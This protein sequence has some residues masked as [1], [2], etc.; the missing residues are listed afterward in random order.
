MDTVRLSTRKPSE[1]GFGNSYGRRVYHAA[2][3]LQPTAPLVAAPLFAA[4]LDAFPRMK[5]DCAL[6][7]CPPVTTAISLTRQH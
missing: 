4:P 6:S 1:N 3:C 5:G 7:L 2:V